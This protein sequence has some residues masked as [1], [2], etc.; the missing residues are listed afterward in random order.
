[1]RLPCSRS[2]IWARPTVSAQRLEGRTLHVE[3]GTVEV[4][5]AII[6]TRDAGLRQKLQ[7]DYERSFAA[8]V[9]ALLASVGNKRSQ[10]GELAVLCG[11]SSGK[12]TGGEEDGGAAHRTGGAGRLRCSGGGS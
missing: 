4:T 1:M 3:P 9:R 5:R 7:T 6:I 8:N 2:I 11:N 10:E 12:R